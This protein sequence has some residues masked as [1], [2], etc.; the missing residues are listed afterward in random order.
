MGLKWADYFHFGNE[1]TDRDRYGCNAE[2]FKYTESYIRDSNHVPKKEF[3]FY[4]NVMTENDR[5]QN[6]LMTLHNG[7]GFWFVSEAINQF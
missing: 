6:L 1:I 3:D 2:L 4:F 5:F 7:E